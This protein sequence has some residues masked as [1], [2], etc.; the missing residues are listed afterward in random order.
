MNK[1]IAACLVAIVGFLAFDQYQ[2]YTFKK[3]LAINFWISDC[4]KEYVKKY[5]W[6]GD[7][8]QPTAE[9]HC[10]KMADEHLR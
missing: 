7:D 1:L 8:A 4:E 10:N 3:R 2:A 9:K 6:L 5:E